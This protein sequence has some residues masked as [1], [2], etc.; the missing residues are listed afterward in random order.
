VFTDYEIIKLPKKTDVLVVETDTPLAQN[1]RIFD[2]FKTFNIIEFKSANNPFR[3][4]IDVPKILVYIGGI[5]LNEKKA[6]LENTTFTLLNARKPMKL[7]K[8]YKKYIQRVK[9]GVYLIERLVQVPVYIVLANEVQGNLDRELALIKEFSTGDERVRF[10]ETVLHEVLKGNQT[11][12]EY[13]HFTFSLYRSKVRTILKEK[14]VNMTIIEKNVREWNEELG[15]KDEYI[16]QGDK[17]RQL[18]DAKKML[19]KGFSIDD[20]MDITELSREEV[21]NLKIK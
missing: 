2:Y 3:V 7:F 14:G 21:V 6:T 13:L 15:L 8:A 11:L 20:I 16:K 18:R 12:A 19:E 4:G 10:I 5:L 9:N 1:L 17:R